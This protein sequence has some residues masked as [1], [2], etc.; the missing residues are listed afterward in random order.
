MHGA[1]ALTVWFV[2]GALIGLLWT[3]VSPTRSAQ[4]GWS[5]VVVGGTGAMLGGAL[6]SWVFAR[7]G[8]ERY[9]FSFPVA[10]AV[11]ALALLM[12]KAVA[13]RRRGLPA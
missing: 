4:S 10:F 11:A 8:G 12:F 2:V 5:N 13:G 1:T 9:V 7:S 6:T 3:N